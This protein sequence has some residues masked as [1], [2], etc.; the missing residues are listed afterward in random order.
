MAANTWLPADTLV[1]ATTNVPET[2][3]ADELEPRRRVEVRQVGDVVAARL[4][5][6]A[7]YEGRVTGMAV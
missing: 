2:M 1:F 4:A 7:I 5:V 6:H 3:V